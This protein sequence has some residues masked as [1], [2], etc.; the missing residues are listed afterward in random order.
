MNQIHPALDPPCYHNQS[1]ASLGRPQL[2]SQHCASEKVTTIRCNKAP[3]QILND[4][5]CT[6]GIIDKT[7]VEIDIKET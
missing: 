3:V 4:K 7:A 5:A 2:Y 6:T 1:D